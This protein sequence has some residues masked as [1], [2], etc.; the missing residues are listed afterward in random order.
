MKLAHR[1]NVVN[2]KYE[3]AAISYQQSDSL[4]HWKLWTDGWT[5]NS[6]WHVW[7]LVL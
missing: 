5:L 2:R 6:N 7:A 1:T 4:S 3:A